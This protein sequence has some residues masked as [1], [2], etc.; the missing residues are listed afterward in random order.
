MVDKSKIKVEILK[1]PTEEDWLWA[2]QCTLNTVGK[3][4]KSSTKEVD[5]DYKK[6]LLASEHS[7]IRELWFGFRLNIPCFISI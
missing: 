5:L 7:P 4:L 3:K 1:R 2:K 6:K